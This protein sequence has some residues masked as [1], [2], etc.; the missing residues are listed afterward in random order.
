ML[1]F[2][3][4]AS[5]MLLW[6]TCFAGS[7]CTEGRNSTCRNRLQKRSLFFAEKTVCYRDLGCF[8][9]GPLLPP[10][11]PPP[12][13]ASPAPEGGGHLVHAV[14]APQQAPAHLP[15]PQECQ[16][17]HLRPLRPD[18]GHHPRVQRQPGAHLMDPGKAHPSA[19]FI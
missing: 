12:Q 7:A 11:V 3:T 9:S 2:W 18:P 6:S 17:V 5:L 4:G 10:R 15:L 16:E 14:H 19:S 1:W 13:S 8:S